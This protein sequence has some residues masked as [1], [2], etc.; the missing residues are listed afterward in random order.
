MA[1]ISRPSTNKGPSTWELM[2]IANRIVRESNKSYAE[3]LAE[4][5]SVWQAENNQKPTSSG[6]Q[7]QIS[8]ARKTTTKAP[9]PTP[10]ATP[11][12]KQDNYVSQ[13][14]EIVEA[15]GGPQM[16]Q[17]RTVVDPGERVDYSGM[18][19]G[20]L[21][22]ALGD[23]ASNILKVG[24]QNINLD[25]SGNEA[26]GS[27]V[28]KALGG[29]EGEYAGYGEAA[30]AYNK[31]RQRVINYYRNAGKSVDWRTAKTRAR[32]AYAKSLQSYGLGWA[33]PLKVLQGEA[34]QSILAEQYRDQLNQAQDAR[35]DKYQAD[36]AY[37]EAL[38][39]RIA[40]QYGL[41]N[42]MM[43]DS[44]EYKQMQEAIGVQKQL[45]EQQNAQMEQLASQY[46]QLRQDYEERDAELSQYLEGMG[47][48]ER[49]NLEKQ[50]A[51]LKA[52]QKEDL[53]R[54]GLTSSSA[55]NAALRGVD[56]AANESLGAM[57]E[58][59]RKEKMTWKAQF[60]GETL[61]A[62]RDMLAFRERASR[63]GFE[64]GTTVPQTMAQLAQ[65]L[66]DQRIAKENQQTGVIGAALGAEAQ[67][68][69]AMQS[70]AASRYASLMGY[71]SDM[72]ATAQ[73]E[74]A[75]IRDTALGKYKTDRDVSLGYANLANQ[76]TLEGIR[77]KSQVAANRA[78]PGKTWPD[79]LASGKMKVGSG[80]SVWT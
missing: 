71:K 66:S 45:V 25:Y 17:L 74:S 69:G 32:A 29:L 40:E 8:A 60:S 4:A 43:E 54:R 35:F 27:N 6:S 62:Q 26:W 36:L 59:L 57:E 72:A 20:Q 21:K 18:D 77:G 5:N 24:G 53:M 33:N 13:V 50:R 52:S 37:N 3:A 22:E 23:Q 42:K 73:R 2:N 47:E 79:L 68:F 28:L 19:Y 58:R 75:S 63:M 56:L 1:I 61:G 51:Q 78:L 14:K 12:P 64:A 34:G 11:A 9:A 44:P 65:M 31:E 39:N 16:E 70:A 67:R 7:A 80:P 46:T 49:R 15:V 55:L 76:Q 38:K 10:T 41:E 48:T 30:D